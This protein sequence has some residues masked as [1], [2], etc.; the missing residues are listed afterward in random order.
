M[1]V[2]DA[3]NEN[4][5]LMGMD[6]I[7]GE[8]IPKGLYHLV[9]GVLIRHVDGDF[10]LM[11]RDFGKKDYPGYYEATAGGSALK[12]ES[13]VEAVFREAFEETG[14]QLQR[15]KEINKV[16]YGSSIFY[17]Y[18]GTADGDKD[19][20]VLQE[21]ETINFKWLNTGDF[22][23]YMASDRC[24]DLIKERLATYL[25]ELW[26]K[27]H[28]PKFEV[29]PINKGWSEDKK[30]LLQNKDEKILL[31]LSKIEDLPRKEHE[32]AMLKKVAELGINTSLPLAL[33]VENEK[34]LMT[35]TWVEGEDL[36][37]ELKQLPKEKQYGLGLEAGRLLKKIHHIPAPGGLLG[38]EERFNEKIDQK[39][40][41]YRAAGLAF[42]NDEAFI[43]FIDANRHLLK[44]RHQSFLHGDFHEG[45]L[46]LTP[47]GNIGIIDFNRMDFEDPWQEFSR[48]I[49]CSYL[50]PEFA[51]GRIDG[52]FD[53]KAPEEF[54]K[55]LALYIAVNALSSIIWAEGFKDDDKALMR[56]LAQREFENYK[57]FKTY[58][59][60]WYRGS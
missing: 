51:T 9:V 4:E 26:V 2:W 38:W 7:R 54:F 31:R 50:S 49:F 21:G 27:H 13:P 28:Y 43:Q 55:L 59:P 45:N 6:L 37:K 39:I 14:I 3:Y 20:I 41:H 16:K 46:V 25:E 58:M 60:N 52:Y 22:L 48:I 12:G 32:F 35:L 1:E 18:L 8:P 36:R 53:G 24:I 42:P 23:E 57:G 10:L 29:T 33:K 19:A 5:E 11:Q 47:K 30:Y 15:V 34:V 56:K 44:G 17:C 40:R